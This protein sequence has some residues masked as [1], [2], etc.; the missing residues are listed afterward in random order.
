MKMINTINNFRN[1]Y[2]SDDGAWLEEFFKFMEK[3]LGW[4]LL[5]YV[6]VYLLIP[7]ALRDFVINSLPSMCEVIK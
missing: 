4:F 2:Y 3:V 1:Y 7:L 6:I 5:Y